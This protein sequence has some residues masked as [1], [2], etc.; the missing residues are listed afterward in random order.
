MTKA[1]LLRLTEEHYGA[2]SLCHSIGYCC[3]SH[4][5]AAFLASLAALSAR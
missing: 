2:A 5:F 3:I 1:F 4:Y